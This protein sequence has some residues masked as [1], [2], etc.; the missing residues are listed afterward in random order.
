[1]G[2]EVPLRPAVQTELRQRQP[3]PPGLFYSIS[4]LQILIPNHAA[5]PDSTAHGSQIEDGAETRYH[6][7]ALHH[8]AAPSPPPLHL[9]A[10]SFTQISASHYRKGSVETRVQSQDGK[11]G[12]PQQQTAPYPPIPTPALFTERSRIPAGRPR[13][14][15]ST[16]HPLTPPPAASTASA[17]GN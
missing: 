13:P 9:P 7:R 14:A 15:S 12:P 2:P 8:Q 5:E 16:P 3:S 6:P 4:P 1:M 11:A 10:A 17:T